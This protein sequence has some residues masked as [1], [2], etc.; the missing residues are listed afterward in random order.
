MNA[1]LSISLEDLIRLKADARGFSFLPRQ[2]VASL[3]SG[4]HGS[5]LRGRGLAFEELRRYQQG[6]DIRTI[7]WKATA[8]LRTPYVRVYT[9]ERERS[10]LFVLDQRQ[11][12]YFGSRRTMKSVL[13]AEV[14]APATWRSLSVGHRVVGT[15]FNDSEIDIYAS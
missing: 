10:V 7:D 9:E 5:R 13:G 11:S 3:L 1:Y 14:A 4:R 8:R 2:P 6:D 12:M 15:I